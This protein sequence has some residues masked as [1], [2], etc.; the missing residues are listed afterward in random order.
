M[1]FAKIV[2]LCVLS[3]C[4]YGILHDVTVGQLCIEF[5]SV[6]RAKVLP[7]DAAI[8]LG[9]IWGTA[10]SW[11]VGLLLGF[12]L[13]VACRFGNDYPKIDSQTLVP[14]IQNF[15]GILYAISILFGL[16]GFALA[17]WGIWS[18]LPPLPSPIAPEKHARFLACLWAQRAAYVFGFLGGAVLIV[19]TFRLRKKA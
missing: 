18:E 16:L 14:S 1:E 6:A 19:H 4:C 13:A 3:A 11:W 15:L 12:A 5:L 9:I 7:V 17:Q 8:L 2:F 10:S